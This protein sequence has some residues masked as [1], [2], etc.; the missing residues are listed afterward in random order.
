MH[1]FWDLLVRICEAEVL[2]ITKPKGVNG[3]LNVVEDVGI[4][5]IHVFLNRI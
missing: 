5:P 2:W 1:A 3:V 4:K